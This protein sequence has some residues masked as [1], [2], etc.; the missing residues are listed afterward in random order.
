MQAF[1][2]WRATAESLGPF[3]LFI[4]F[5]GPIPPPAP[6]P[7]FLCLG[8]NSW[9]VPTICTGHIVTSFLPK[10]PGGVTSLTSP[11]RGVGLNSLSDNRLHMFL[12]WFKQI[13]EIVSPTILTYTFKTGKKMKP[14][15]LCCFIISLL[16]FFSSCL[17]FPWV[18]NIKMWI[19]SSPAESVGGGIINCFY[20]WACRYRDFVI[21]KQ[22]TTH[23][24]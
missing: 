3:S 4:H 24:W 21:T 6:F 20:F 8:L 19:C 17:L 9:S 5:L 18:F 23:M 11:P 14:V 7:H 15:K 2:T 1:I 13:L 16:F 22:A 10:A 12:Q